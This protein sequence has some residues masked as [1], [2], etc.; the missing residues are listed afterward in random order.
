M[1][2]KKGMGGEA[3]GGEAIGGAKIRTY[4]KDGAPFEAK[5]SRVAPKKRS[6]GSKKK[7]YYIHAGVRG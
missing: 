3:I 2:K 7:R 4:Y 5:K 6:Q 1:E